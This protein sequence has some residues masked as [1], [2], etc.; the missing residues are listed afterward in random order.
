MKER[1]E[2][3][4][5]IREKIEQLLRDDLF[6]IVEGRP[7]DFPDKIEALSE[8]DRHEKLNSIGYGLDRI[9]SHLYDIHVIARGDKE[10]WEDDE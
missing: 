7:K 1:I 6:E 2:D 3:L 4:G 5:R 8:D 9:K 10:F